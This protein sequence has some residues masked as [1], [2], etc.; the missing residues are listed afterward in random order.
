MDLC[1][2]T[3][4]PGKLRSFLSI[5]LRKFVNLQQQRFK[6]LKN[7]SVTE[8]PTLPNLRS[9][10]RLKASHSMY[11]HPYYNSSLSSL[12]ILSGPLCYIKFSLTFLVYHVILSSN[13]LVP[14]LFAVYPRK[15]YL[16]RNVSCLKN[17][18]PACITI[19]PAY[20]T[21]FP[22]FITIFPV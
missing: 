10:K 7:R 16:S 20:I 12:L 5:F 19:F 15:Q 21:I 17:D 14:C 18:F 4:T 6:S 3:S 13:I 11:L 22:V 9:K 2:R 1:I 8:A